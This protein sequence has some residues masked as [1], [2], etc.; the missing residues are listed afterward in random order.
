MLKEETF[1]TKEAKDIPL[2][3]FG[4]KISFFRLPCYQENDRPKGN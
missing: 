3:A 2:Y 1:G 4:N